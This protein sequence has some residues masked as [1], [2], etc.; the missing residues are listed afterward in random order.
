MNSKNEEE[1][2]LCLE[3]EESG[4]M[5][6]EHLYCDFQRVLHHSCLEVLHYL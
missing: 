2:E 4:G 6:K 5:V 1:V 3:R